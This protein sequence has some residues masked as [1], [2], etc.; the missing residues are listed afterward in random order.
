M[1]IFPILEIEDRLQ[2]NDKTRLNATKSFV[3]TGSTAISSMQFTPGK[4]ATAITITSATSS[5][6]FLDYA[7]SSQTVDV[8]STNNK[9]NFK[10]SSSE[11]TAT[12][13]DGNYTF[14]QLA[15]EIQTQ[16]NSAGSLTYTVSYSSTT[17]KFTIA[18]T[19]GFS[20]L[21]K[22][23]TNVATSIFEEIGFPTTDDNLGLF[24]IEDKTGRA[25]YTGAKVEYVNK[26]ITITASDGSTTASQAKVMK[27]Y[28]VEGDKLFSSDSELQ[29]HEDDILKWVRSG[30]ASFLDKHRLAQDHILDELDRAGYTDIYSE[31]LTKDAIVDIQEV[32]EWS[33]YK[34]LSF[35]FESLSNAVDDVFSVKA[36]KYD[37]MALKKKDRAM[38]RLDLTKDGKVDVDEFLSIRSA[39][40]RRV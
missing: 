16:L 11:L 30:R 7:F 35:I 22:T 39:T 10:E 25:T 6:W 32:R 18:A 21:L 38:L 2:V 15:S 27:I 28:S 9:L 24:D 36:K 34:T 17:L 20:L 8:D 33:K 4:N 1:A 29:S 31:R 19:A 5:D 26:E 3:T 23:G 13:S 14:A 37:D 12:L 40:L